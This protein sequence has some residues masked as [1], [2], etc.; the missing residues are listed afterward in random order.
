MGRCFDPPPQQQPFGRYDGR[1]DET[2]SGVW[3]T[4]AFRLGEVT[5]FSA[6]TGWQRRIQPALSQPMADDEVLTMR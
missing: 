1:D 6:L 2:D 5:E 3:C 4:S